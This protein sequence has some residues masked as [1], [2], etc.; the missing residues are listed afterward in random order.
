MSSDDIKS[1]EYQL[2]LFGL[3]EN[4]NYL[5]DNEI[6][7]EEDAQFAKEDFIYVQ[8][9][10]YKEWNYLNSNIENIDS[11]KLKNIS[12]TLEKLFWFIEALSQNDSV[13][14]K[15]YE[16]LESYADKIEELVDNLKT[17]P[18]LIFSQ[19]FMVTGLDIIMDNVFIIFNHVYN[20]IK[21]TK[22]DPKFKTIIISERDKYDEILEKTNTEKTKKIIANARNNISKIKELERI[23][24][25]EKALLLKDKVKKEVET[26]CHSTNRYNSLWK[27]REVLGHGHSFMNIKK[28]AHPVL[29]HIVEDIFFQE[30]FPENYPKIH[31]E[32]LGPGMG[33]DAL[34]LLNNLPNIQSFRATDISKTVVKKFRKR[35]HSEFAENYKFK[36]ERRNIKIKKGDFNKH[37][38]TMRQEY[39]SLINTPIPTLFVSMSTMH[40]EWPDVLQ[41]NFR[42]IARICK[43]SNGMFALALKT[44]QS[45]SW[46]EHINLGS[47]GIDNKERKYYIGIHPKEMLMRAFISPE[48]INTM[49][50]QAGFDMLNATAFSKSIEYD[51]KGDREMFWCVVAKAK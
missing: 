35:V 27:L 1:P 2:P 24:N 12:D 49:L 18:K 33:N 14:S 46:K 31:V 51:F 15:Q 9:H 45:A 47:F 28:E 22:T 20:L 25:I 37:L 38:N 39:E 5:E 6:I 29:K 17:K 40:Y 30:Q 48:Q 7:T 19:N 43:K 11:S 8:T 32:E 44:P 21:K 50:Y 42:N 4:S 13:D 36:T 3:H 26:Y 34:Y 41:E 10:L 23:G 16:I